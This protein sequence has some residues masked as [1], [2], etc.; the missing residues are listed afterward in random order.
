M[1]VCVPVSVCTI[2]IALVS[3][4]ASRSTS[5]LNYE[6]V[7]RRQSIRIV[8]VPTVKDTVLAIVQDGCAYTS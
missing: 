3:I 4:I 6:Y 2:Q 7:V 5:L 8:L 1:Q